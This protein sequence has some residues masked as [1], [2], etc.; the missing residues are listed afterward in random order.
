MAIEDEPTEI[1]LDMLKGTSLTKQ[2]WRKAQA[3]DRS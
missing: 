2:D 1:P 3:S